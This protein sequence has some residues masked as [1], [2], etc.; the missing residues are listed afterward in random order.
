MRLARFF[1]KLTCTCYA[2]YSLK[3]SRRKGVQVKGA[4]PTVGKKIPRQLQCLVL[5]FDCTHDKL[6]IHEQT[7]MC[8]Y[9]TIPKTI[10]NSTETWLIPLSTHAFPP[11]N[12]IQ[13]S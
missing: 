1:P 3:A 5:L 11:Q 4:T 10:L 6:N 9:V 2:V 8:L 13:V 12:L 7:F